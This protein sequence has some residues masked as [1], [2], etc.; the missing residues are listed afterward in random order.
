MFATV[1][2]NSKLLIQ[3]NSVGEAVEV[4][5]HHTAANQPEPGDPLISNLTI[6]E[7]VAGTTRGSLR[8]LMQ[9]TREIRLIKTLKSMSLLPREL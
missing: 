8:N 4:L 9:H 3:V 6:M 1:S 2:Y 5:K 7:T